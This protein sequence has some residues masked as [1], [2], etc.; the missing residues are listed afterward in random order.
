MNR[1]LLTSLLAIFLL[2]LPL[3]S[4]ASRRSDIEDS[5]DEW[6]NY[7]ED[8][9]YTIIDTDIDQIDDETYMTYTIDLERGS[10]SI[11]AQ[12]A[13][14]IINLDMAVYYEDDYEN[15]DPEPFVE[16]TYDDNYPIVE[17][18][19]R[20]AE[21]IVVEIWVEEFARHVDEDYYC[22]LFAQEEDSEED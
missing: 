16:D 18:E 4:F 5:L 2:S 1:I 17:F 14:D 8:E 10:Y 21:T 7:A 6:S 13:E 22:I 11:L 15:E 20:H 19:L 3:A 9:G 12:G